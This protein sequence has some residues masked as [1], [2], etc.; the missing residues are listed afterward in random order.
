MVTWDPRKQNIRLKT[1]PCRNFVGGRWNV[2]DVR[3]QLNI[4]CAI[5]LLRVHLGGINMYR[6][7][8]SI[9]PTVRLWI[10]DIRDFVYCSL[11]KPRGVNRSRDSRPGDETN[12]KRMFDYVKNC[13]FQWKVIENFPKWSRTFIK[14]SDFI[15]F[16]ESDK[17]QISVKTFRKNSI[18]SSTKVRIWN[19]R[20]YFEHRLCA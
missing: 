12:E 16:R 18:I 7:V 6:I 3:R 8:S 2:S 1:L 10:H 17:W 11:L 4:Q 14:F 5:V 9:N 15:E 13:Y 19:F 20:I